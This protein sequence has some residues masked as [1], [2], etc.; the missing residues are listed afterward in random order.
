MIKTQKSS[1]RPLRFVSNPEEIIIAFC[2]A[3][4]G[5]LRNKS[6]MGKGMGDYYW[7]YHICPSQRRGYTRQGAQLISFG[8]LYF[9]STSLPPSLSPHFLFP[10]LPP[11]HLPISLPSSLLLFFPFSFS[12][13]SMNYL[14][15]IRPYAI[16]T[17]NTM[18]QK[19]GSTL[20][21]NLD[22]S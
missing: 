4:D 12:Q 21:G 16:E 5:L 2:L 18:L 8:E 20:S 9:L 14:F 22:I 10:F 19:T 6:R 13:I 7:W 3:T 17:G 15:C 11:T 1:S